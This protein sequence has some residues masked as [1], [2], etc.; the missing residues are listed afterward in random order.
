MKTGY[1]INNSVSKYHSCICV[2][3]YEPENE[4]VLW[5]FLTEKECRKEKTKSDI[6]IWK[7]KK[8]K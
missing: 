2:S 4:V 5:S 3:N 8:R 7:I 1:G 6:G